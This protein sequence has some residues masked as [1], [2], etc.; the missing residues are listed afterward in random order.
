M[1]PSLVLVK[2]C[3]CKR[4]TPFFP[5]QVCLPLVIYIFLVCFFFE[6]KKTYLV[7]MFAQRSVQREINRQ[8]ARSPSGLVVKLQ[9]LKIKAR[10]KGE[11]L[12]GFDWAIAIADRSKSE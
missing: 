12:I 7:I 11:R 6:R 3:V 1:L 9:S 10:K 4:A 5:T 8:D 2:S